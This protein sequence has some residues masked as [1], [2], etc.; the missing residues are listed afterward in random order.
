VL[1]SPADALRTDP[2]FATLVRVDAS[3]DVRS[4]TF[5]DHHGFIAEVDIPAAAPPNV[6]SAFERSRLC[7][8]YAW[9]SYE[10]MVTAELEGF[11]S[12]ELALKERLGLPSS[13]K[14]RLPGLRARLA[15]AV[16]RG[17]IQPPT[18]DELGIDLHSMMA[19]LRNDLSHGTADVHSP[20]MAITVIQWCADVI[21]ELYP[22]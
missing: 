14:E 2:R 16:E 11:G 9:F 7:F 5:D 20:D 19:R 13:K 4:A 17:F 10:L 6:R 12:L 8:L 22:K 21:G 3:G 18:V 15:A 1:K